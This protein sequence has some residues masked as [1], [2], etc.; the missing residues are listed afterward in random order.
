VWAAR[1]DLPALACRGLE[2][3]RIS[4]GVLGGRR[5]ARVRGVLVRRR[6][7][8]APVWLEGTGGGTG[9]GAGAG[10]GAGD[11]DRDRAGSIEA[12]LGR[13]A[14]PAE[15]PGLPLTL[16]RPGRSWRL[17]VERAQ[18]LAVIGPTQSGKT[19]SLAVPAILGWDGP[20]LA[21]S[22]KTDLLR[23]T[24]AWRSSV[25]RVQCFDPSGVTGLVTDEWSPLRHA[26]TW[27]G[28]RRA[29]AD[30]TEVARAEGTT[31]DG[32]F[33]YATAAKLLAPLLFAAATGGRTM[34][35]VVRWVDTQEVEEV[36]G[37]L[38][39]AGV[40]EA[41]HAAHAT[42]G[43]DDRQ[44]S[45]VYT[46]AETVLEGFGPGSAGADGSAGAG[47]G[48][49]SVEIDVPA[50][51]GGA[52]TL[53]VCAPAHDQR[54]QRGLFSAVVKD[55]LDAAFTAAATT[56]GP[57]EHPLLVV[58]DEAANI[59]PVPELDGLAATCAG[60]GIQLVTIWQD[61]AQITAR[62]GAR[63]ATVVNNHRAKLFLS[64]I[65]D[66]GTLEH[67]SALVGD[68]DVLVPS[69]TRDRSGAESTTMAPTRRR[70]LAPDALRRLE[71][72]TAV[73]VYGSL[74]PALVELR[75]WWAD[76]V[77]AARGHASG[78]A[79]PGGA[80]SMGTAGARPGPPDPGH[81]ARPGTVQVGDPSGRSGNPDLG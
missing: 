36:V 40:V 69:V 7:P 65:A 23:D 66:P 68:E 17:A 67:A 3:G 21:V 9:A 60:H 57:L 32:E 39:A 76:P 22:V 30:L 61:L 71:P 64:G 45:S 73:L 74:R 75:P 26:T 18:S 19:T 41:L 49:R 59:A 27:P 11:P 33:W 78:A 77:L 25:G 53:Y 34:R 6:G 16:S 1:R 58:L 46:T 50:L 51:L 29:A 38:E 10:A 15:A 54:R 28:A 43:R 2:S 44:R 80:G 8:R 52:H 81:P 20:V 4:L 63:A 37:L 12:G 55:V 79:L 5:P 24:R 56:G 72:G 47:G 14:D 48:R 70:L 35:D 31:A 62:Y 13:A 42:W